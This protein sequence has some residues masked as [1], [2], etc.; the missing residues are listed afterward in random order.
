MSERLRTWL[1]VGAVLVAL[2]LFAG[3]ELVPAARIWIVLVLSVAFIGF[4]IWAYL[5]SRTANEV[6]D[7]EDLVW[8]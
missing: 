7:A 2:V 4:V 8:P 5:G 1:T 3:L 6:T